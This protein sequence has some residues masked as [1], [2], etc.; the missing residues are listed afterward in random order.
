MNNKNINIL[1]IA[2]FF[3]SATLLSALFRYRIITI[4]MLSDR[5]PTWIDE[6]GTAL[7]TGVGV[8]VA[9]IVARKWLRQQSKTQIS[10]L[11]DEPLLSILMSLLPIL[12]LTIIGVQ[13]PYSVPIHL[14]GFTAITATLLYCVLE[15]YGWR[16]YL[17]EELKFLK[18]WIR[19]SL[20]GLIW[21][22]WHL[23]FLEDPSAL[24]VLTGLGMLILASW[25]IGQLALLTHSILVVACFH[26][27]IQIMFFNAF[28]R[29]LLTGRDKLIIFTIL[30]VGWLILLKLWQ[31]KSDEKDLLLNT[32]FQE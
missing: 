14:W 12:L 10:L 5:I 20:I 18:P 19:Y 6:L 15:E 11:G 23:S 22:I 9:A 21:Y 28:F 27:L 32:E 7:L 31:K 25:G 24:S 4:S 2:L 8:W 13:N 16:G 29:E 17:Q 1:R 3:V 26:L 30:L